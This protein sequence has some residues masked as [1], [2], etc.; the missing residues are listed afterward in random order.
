MVDFSKYIDIAHP[1]Q[2]FLNWQALQTKLSQLL[3]MKQPDGSTV[4][5]TT[6]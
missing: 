6:G 4:Q 2:H 5:S 1:I 3:E